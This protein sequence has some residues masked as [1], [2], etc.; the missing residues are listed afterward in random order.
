MRLI[1]AFVA[2]ALSLGIPS[3]VGADQDSF[4]TSEPTWKLGQ[5]DTRL[6]KIQH[7]RVFDESHSGNG[8]EYLKVAHGQGTYAYLQYRVTPAR[9]M[10]ELNP[11]I[12]IKSNHPHLQLLAR[13]VLPRTSDPHTGKPVTA[14]LPGTTYDDVNN[15]Q[16]LSIPMI[17]SLLQ[18]RV[19]ALRSQFGSHLD[20]RQAYV[21]MVVLNTY[22]APGTT[23]LWIDDFEMSRTTVSV[24]PESAQPATYIDTP[25]ITQQLHANPISIRGSIILVD[26]QPFFPRVIKHNGESIQFLAGL[27]F[28]VIALNR[29][30]TADESVAASQFGLWFTVPY[31]RPSN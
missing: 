4:E 23:N 9:L 5:T 31:V 30:P 20:A 14:L 7:Q 29:L 10:N 12:L 11:R 1:C 18:Q 25:G 15:W 28:N 24:G 22:S 19:P 3:T 6:I 21:D 16:Q 17:K 26:S 13:V 8:A 2:I 27:G